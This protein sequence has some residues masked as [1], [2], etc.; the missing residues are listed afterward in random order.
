MSRKIIMCLMSLG[1]AFAFL[2]FGC[3]SSSKLND[4]IMEINR[5]RTQTDYFNKENQELKAKM[6]DF[7]GNIERLKFDLGLVRKEVM[8][9]KSGG[10]Q[11]TQPEQVDKL[12]K[13][14]ANPE[15]DI[16]LVSEKLREYGKQS[17]IA[18]VQRLKDTDIDFLRRVE[19]SLERMAPSDAVPLLLDALRQPEIRNSAARVLGRLNDRSAVL[20]LA[21]YL[22]KGEDSDFV[23]TVAES[24]VK[25]KDRR[26]I[27]VLIEN[28]KSDNSA[29]RALS[30]DALSKSTG[31]TF[32]YK[33]YLSEEERIMAVQ[34]WEEWW[35]KEGDKFDFK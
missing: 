4:C 2:G 31:Q 23:F 21:E 12:I 33:P 7:E 28:L 19:M 14:L 32:N 3:A 20:P 22:K 10:P 29:R 17:V 6:K 30:F 25:L 1:L 9:M 35:A 26:G 13:E 16:A 27:P 18:L 5:L 8:D 15:S 24:L 34:K 11:P